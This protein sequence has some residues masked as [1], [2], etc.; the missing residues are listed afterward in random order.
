M[1]VTM[2]VDASATPSG[3]S[4]DRRDIPIFVVATVL[5]PTCFVVGLRLYTRG[6]VVSWLGWND[7]TAAIAMVSSFSLMCSQCT[8]LC[9]QP[10]A[11]A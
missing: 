9:N 8:A 7:W 11:E 10:G 2:S 1:A 4:P 6:Y 3:H 5:P